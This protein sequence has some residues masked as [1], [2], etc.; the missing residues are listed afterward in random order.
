MW[1]SS[2]SLLRCPCSRLATLGETLGRGS[3]LLRTVPICQISSLYPELLGAAGPKLT[4]ESTDKTAQN[5]VIPEK[6]HRTHTHTHIH[7][8]TPKFR[9]T[10]WHA[11]TQSHGHVH[12]IHTDTCRQEKMDRQRAGPTPKTATIKPRGTQ[13]CSDTGAGNALS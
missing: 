9:Q 11:N 8:H 3:A 2:L 10:R 1:P 13:M 5:P 6:V 12:I 7:T 4:T